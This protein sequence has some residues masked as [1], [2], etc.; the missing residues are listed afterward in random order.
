MWIIFLLSPLLALII[1]ARNFRLREFHIFIIL[2]FALYG[3][4]YIPI[5]DSDVENHLEYFSQISRLSLGQF[6]EL[7]TNV[8]SADARNPDFYLEVVAYFSSRI[9]TDPKFFLLAIAILYYTALVKLVSYIHSLYKPEGAK[10]QY[11]FLFLLG[12]FVALN[13]SSGLNGIRFPMAFMVFSLGAVKFVVT[14]ER[15]YLLFALLSIFVHFSLIYSCIFLIIYAIFGYPKKNIFLYGLLLFAFIFSFTL[16][17]LIQSNIG[18]L[19]QAVGNKLTAYTDEYYIDLRETHLSSVNWYV[20]LNRFSTYYFTLA[21][22]LL[23]KVKS[24]NVKFD[25]TADNL[26]G[27]SVIMLIHN[28]F[29]GV[30]VDSLSNRYYILFN[31]FALAY[32]FYLGN[33]NRTN[34]LLIFSGRIYIFVLALHILVLLR[35]DL[36]TVSPILIF[37]NIFLIF[38]TESATSIQDLFLG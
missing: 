35:G 16:G 25:K 9:S 30:V 15:K 32:L 28:L 2:F 19:G 38:I 23:S 20:Q 34:K 8:Y 5:P 7:I 37:G 36:Y 12:C 6:I 17:S 10:R 29:S 3:Y 14:R 4:T 31:F 22:L 27:F 24:F 13:I 33:I 1:A 26:F 21:V 18:I 11:F